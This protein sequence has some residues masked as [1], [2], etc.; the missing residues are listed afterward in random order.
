MKSEIRHKKASLI[1]LS[2]EEVVLNEN[3]FGVISLVQNYQ[4]P[5]CDILVFDKLVGKA[6]ALFLKE[7]KPKY[8]Y[9][10]VITKEAFE[11]LKEFNVEY[12]SIVEHILNRDKSDLCPIEKIAQECDDVF[13]LYKKTFIFYH[14]LGVL[15]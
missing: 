15:K 14:K 12:D 4:K 13:E 2:E 5:Y 6:G 11:I 8:I 10:E 9:A 3:K 1:F 7:Y